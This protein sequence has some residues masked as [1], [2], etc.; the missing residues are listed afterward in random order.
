MLIDTH[1]HLNFSD[2]D[3]DRDQIIQKCLDNNIW[4]INV[5]TDLESSRK[6][7]EIAQ[8]GV[9][10]SVGLHPLN[11]E[12]FDIK[13]LAQLDSVV[14]IGEAG[15]DYYKRPKNKTKRKEF[16]DKQKSVFLT[17]A[18]IA[19]DLD[20]PMIIHCRYAHQDMVS[21]L[22]GL[23]G[24]IHCFTGNVD[25]LEQYLD[26]GFYIGFNGIIFKLNL[27]DVILKTPIDKILIETDCPYLNPDLTANR[28]DPT[29]LIK[30]AKRIAEIKNI[31]LDLLLE[32]TS[33]NAKSLFKFNP[34]A[35]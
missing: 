17:Q 22:D 33:K 30:V 35:K 11:E 32:K 25:E 15:L 6:A 13:S 1:A 27:D 9:Y 2:F 16:E 19:S 20:L 31:E 26:L 28:N 21:M 12:M 5:G 7:I 29:N 3:S 14:A 4:I 34:F 8:K 24:V 23:K 18:S 10:A